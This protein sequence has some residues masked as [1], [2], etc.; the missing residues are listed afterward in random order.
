MTI[1]F[2]KGHPSADLLPREELAAEYSRILLET[3]FL[4]Y[5]SDPINRGPLQYGT[6]AGNYDVRRTI[7]DWNNREFKTELSQPQHINLTAGASYG[8]ANALTSV[9][10]EEHTKLAFIVTPT[11]FL[12][13]STFVD[14]GLGGKIVSIA[15][16]LDLEYDIDV[17]KLEHQLAQYEPVPADKEINIFHDEAGRAD[18]KFFRFVLYMV[19]TFSNPGG[20]TYSVRTRMKIL[21]LARK[22][23]MLIISDDVY[24]LLDYTSAKERIP[25]M[26]YLDIESRPAAKTFGNTL[27]NGTFSKILAPGV[28]FGW[29]ETATNKLSE[30]LAVTGAN[31]SGGTPGQ[32]SS[33]VVKN[34]I[35]N[36]SLDRIITK[37]ISIYSER[38]QRLRQVI[39]VHLPP[40]TTVGGGD[41]GYFFWISIPGDI[42]LEKVLDSL[43]AKGVIIPAGKN[44][45]VCSNEPPI[46]KNSV[47][48]SISSLSPEQI[49][50]GIRLFGTEL[51]STYPN[52]Y[53]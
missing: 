47:R 38:A 44:F 43:R 17:A 40:H 8:A 42:D 15:E 11:Y 49:E 23:D 19:P 20:L 32:L 30:Q 7:S 16:T 27:S 6:D 10:S 50:E 31:K 24:E 21:E 12:I 37:F 9:V 18:R 28:R 36:G 1:N 2:F 3:D 29:Q 51:R 4:S 25:R 53:K 13:N 45:E 48:L 22:Y 35:D 52:L 26:V 14:A 39:P 5:E 34:L 46:W 41:G 33:F